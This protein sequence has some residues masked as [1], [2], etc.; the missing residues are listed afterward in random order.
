MDSSTPNA[1]YQQVRWHLEAIDR[2]ITIAASF[3]SGEQ[4]YDLKTFADDAE[5]VAYDINAY[6]DAP[7]G[8]RIW[9]GATIEKANLAALT[10]WLDWAY[11]TVKSQTQAAAQ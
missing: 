6:R 4:Y 5:D 10:P 2:R 3:P 8:L 9:A 11:A 1:I 7:P